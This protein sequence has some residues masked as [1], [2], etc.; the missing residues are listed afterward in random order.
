MFDRKKFDLI[1]GSGNSVRV[2]GYTTTDAGANVDTAGYFNDLADTLKAGD[3]IIVNS[4]DIMGDVFVNDITKG[5]VD[6]TNLVA[7]TDSD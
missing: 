1:G 5:D 7:S 4:G 6:V 3:K 2:W